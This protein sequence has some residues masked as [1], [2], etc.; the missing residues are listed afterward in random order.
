MGLRARLLSRTWREGCVYPY[1]F[2]RKPWVVSLSMRVLVGK[3]ER[4]T[5]PESGTRLAGAQ[6]IHR[7][8][9]PQD[10]SLARRLAEMFRLRSRCSLRL[11]MRAAL[12]V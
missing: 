4:F 1:A 7:P 11:Y 10:V 5:D 9:G 3:K 12:S 8:V 2:A 6:R